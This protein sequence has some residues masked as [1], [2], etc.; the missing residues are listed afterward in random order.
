MLLLLS[1][2]T[3]RIAIVFTPCERSRLV[4]FAAIC[5]TVAFAS[6]SPN[7][8]W[9][10]TQACAICYCLYAMRT[11][12]TCLYAFLDHRHFVWVSTPRNNYSNIVI[13]YVTRVVL[14]SRKYKGG[15]GALIN[16]DT[17]VRVMFTSKSHC[18]DGRHTQTVAGFYPTTSSF[19]IGTTF[20]PCANK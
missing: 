1:F 18:T 15:E 7:P 12:K 13:L 16:K 14:I 3:S 4:L 20:R 17:R 8:G 9:H 5:A 19:V 2:I 11:L 6:L 10:P